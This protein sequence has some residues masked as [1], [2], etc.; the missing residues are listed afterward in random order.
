MHAPCGAGLLVA[1]GVALLAVVTAALP[2]GY[3]AG[4]GACPT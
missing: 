4:D 1:S 3:T 2:P